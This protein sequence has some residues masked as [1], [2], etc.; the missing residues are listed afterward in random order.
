M[1]L[2]QYKYLIERIRQNQYQY[3]DECQN[4]TEF[5][6]FMQVLHIGSKQST[7]LEITTVKNNLA[8]ADL[9]IQRTCKKNDRDTRKHPKHVPDAEI[10]TNV[11]F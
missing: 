6:P 1:S 11:K 10:C 4:G 2:K 7:D 8:R 3:T 9:I 5:L